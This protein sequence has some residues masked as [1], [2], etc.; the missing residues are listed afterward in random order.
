[1][2]ESSDYMLSE[3]VTFSL[4]NCVIS[5]QIGNEVKI[6]LNPGET[7]DIKIV[8]KDESNPQM[9]LG[10]SIGYYVKKIR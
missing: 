5:G 6:E 9:G 10:R 8:K 3:S 7:R 4:N 2:N 1:M